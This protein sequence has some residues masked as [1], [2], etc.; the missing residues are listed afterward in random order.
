MLLLTVSSGDFLQ[1]ASFPLMALVAV[2]AVLAGSAV[3]K[4][5]KN[6]RVKKALFALSKGDRIVLCNGMTGTILSTS[7]KTVEIELSSGTRA[8]FMEWAVLEVNGAKL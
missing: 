8:R 5:F 2:T 6:K 4:Y 1:G 3:I 7:E